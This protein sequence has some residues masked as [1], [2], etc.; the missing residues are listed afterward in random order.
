MIRTQ[1]KSSLPAVASAAE[2]PSLV[3][4]A[5]AALS[6]ATTAAEVLDARDAATLVYDAAKRAARLQR[7]KAA[8]DELVNATYRVQADALEI[9]SMASLRLANEYDA[10]QARGEVAGKGGRRGNQHGSVGDTNVATAA[11][12]GLSRTQVFE[13]RQ[14]RDAIERE[15]GIVRAALDEM[16]AAR[17]DPTRAALKRAIEPGRA[18]LRAAIGTDTAT[19]AERGNNLYQTPPEA[20]RTLLNFC[21]FTETVWEPACGK[22][23]ISRMLEDAGYSVELSDLVDYGTADRHGE[24]QRAEDFLATAPRGD[25]PNRP[26]IVTNPP[27]GGS[28]NAFVAHAL[29]AHR[30]RRMALLL[31]LNFLCGFDDPDRCF[32]MDEC[33]PATI[34]VFTRRLPM[35]HRDGWD[36]NEAS[37]RMNT[38]WFVWELDEA[39]GTYDAGGTRDTTILR[40]D[41]KVFEGK[42][43]CGP[44]DPSPRSAGASRADPSSPARGEE[45]LLA[46]SQPHEGGRIVAMLGSIEVGAVF[47]EEKGCTWSFWLGTVHGPQKRAKSVDAA[48]AAIDKLFREKTGLAA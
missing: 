35:M 30:P 46:W 19:N 16:L 6:H 28:L 41:W 20:M 15:P 5:A 25:D 10:A 37:S 12:V 9:E 39:T 1:A 23:A 48:K 43:L 13:A 27:Y 2:L 42:A 34:Y 40:V 11:D 4:A 14:M 21:R 7:A 29:K 31:N 36:G 47:P 45:G 22:G 18:N 32:A 33:P 17:A 44:N 26:D 8:H 3:K 38:A 24:L